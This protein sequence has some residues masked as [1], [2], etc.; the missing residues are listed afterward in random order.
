MQKLI[1]FA[2][3]KEIC[4][5]L[6]K[7]TYRNLVFIMHVNLTTPD[8]FI[9]YF[10]ISFIQFSS[11]LLTSLNLFPLV[12][13][14]ISFYRCSFDIVHGGDMMQKEYVRFLK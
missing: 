13:F 4:N 11:F 1:S 12:F 3:K 10:D 5:S 9:V 8:R 6:I 2:Q 7:I 14:D